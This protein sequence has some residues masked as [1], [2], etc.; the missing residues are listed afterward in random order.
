MET[1]LGEI[2]LKWCI[3]YLDD[4]IVFSKTPEEHT[5]R[6][7]GV[8]EKQATVGLKLKPSK[9]EFFKLRVAYLGHIVSKDGIETGPTKIEAI[10]NWP[11]LKTVTEVR[12]FLGFTN[13]YCKFVPKYAQIAKPINQLVSRE[14]AG[15]KKAPVGWTNECQTAFEHLKCLCSQT[16]ILAYVNYEK[17][18]KLHTNASESGL[19]AVLYQKQED[20]TECVI[21]YASRTL[22]KSKRNYESHN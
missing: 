14:N 1:C 16:P 11:I 21:A 15:K 6:L 7:K 9:C 19:G 18:F 20:D 3:I 17:P 5:E 22:S 4:I 12:S 10:K 13:Y 2:H 8:F